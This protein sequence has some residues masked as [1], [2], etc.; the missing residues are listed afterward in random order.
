MQLDRATG[1]ALHLD[2]EQRRELRVERV[3]VERLAVLVELSRVHDLQV[4]D[5]HAKGKGLRAVGRVVH[6]HAAVRVVE[7][8]QAGDVDEPG[9]ELALQAAP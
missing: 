8:T 9:E 4:V 1:K 7:L 6:E 5:V 2:G 3:G